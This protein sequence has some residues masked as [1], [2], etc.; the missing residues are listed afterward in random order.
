MNAVLDTN[1]LIDFLQGHLPA[2]REMKRYEQPAISLITWMEILV[3][4]RTDDE[5]LKLR[6][7]LATF[8]LLHIDNEVAELAV[9][10]RKTHRLRLPDAMIWA[11]AQTLN[12]LLVTRNTRDFPSTDPSIRIPYQLKP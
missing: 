7:F 5:D 9:T 2:K 8:R 11:S 10:L 1:I 4:S 3:G 12:M 6:N